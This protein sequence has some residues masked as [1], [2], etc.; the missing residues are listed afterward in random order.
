MIR[1]IIF[2]TFLLVFQSLS[3]Q[4]GLLQSGPMVGY[5]EM[6]EA[7]LWVQTKAAAKVQIAYWERENP[8]QKYVTDAKITGKDHAYTAKLIADQ[9]QPGKRYDYELRI[10]DQPCK[11]NY[12]T[13]FQTQS[14][15]QWRTDAPDFTMALGSCAYVNEPIYDR[16]GNP[17]GGEYHIFNTIHRMRPDMMLWTGDNI[18]LREADWFTRTGI[19]AR[20]THTRSLP[21]MQPLLASTN[22]FATWD[23]HD[24]G[25][26]NSDASFIQK[27]VT[28]EAFKLFWGNLTYGINEKPGVTSAFQYNDIDFYL[29]DNRS[30]RNPD[31]RATGERALLGKEQ[32]EWLIDGLVNSKAPFKMIVIGNQVLNDSKTVKESYYKL[33]NEERTYLL[34]RIEEENIKNVIFLTGDRHFTELAQYKNARGNMIYDLTVSPLT[35]GIL[36]QVESDNTLRVAGTV[37]QARNFGFLEFKGPKTARTLTIHIYDA[38][39][40]EKW[41]RRITSEP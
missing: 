25:P 26:D 21:E 14:L 37:V 19:I 36:K 34:K 8:D 1:Y 27:E 39:G 28:L 30:W 10:N 15:W 4:Q 32:L 16:P 24:F 13:T 18:Y 17:Y 29:L 5:A 11:F 22:N 23:D 38:D 7:L 20:Y 40:K 6:R 3:A 9:V 2:I 33:Y 31:L 12:A 35:S 41:N